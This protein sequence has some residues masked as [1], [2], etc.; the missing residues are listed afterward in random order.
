M[1]SNAF[2]PS[3]ERSLI[4]S[5][6]E[7]L[8]LIQSIA[9]LAVTIWLVLAG[10]ANMRG[11]DEIAG[12]QQKLQQVAQS[13][14]SDTVLVQQVGPAVIKDISI[15]ATQDKQLKSL[16]VRYGFAGNNNAPAS[17]PSSS[18]AAPSA[19]PVAPSAATPLTPP[20]PKPLGVE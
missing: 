9:V 17:A 20:I 4:A 18:S 14:Q 15:G 1:E 5:L 19:A 16:L 3:N 6:V 10:R 11:S 8:T 13:I 12:L 7:R 2:S